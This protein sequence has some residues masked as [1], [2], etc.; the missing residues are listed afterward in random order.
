[1]DDQTN[2]ST[3]GSQSQT[4]S[5]LRSVMSGEK[6]TQNSV[7]RT[8]DT[9]ISGQEIVNGNQDL[10]DSRLG[11]DKSERETSSSLATNR[12]PTTGNQSPNTDQRTPETSSS[13]SSID[14]HQSATNFSSPYLPKV[15]DLHDRVNGLSGKSEPNT[16]PS[17]NSSGIGTVPPSFGIGSDTTSQKSNK[18]KSG[19]KPFWKQRK[20]QALAAVIALLVTIIGGA[21]GLYLSQQGTDLRQ[22]ASCSE[23]WTVT[24]QG[25]GGFD[26]DCGTPGVFGG[27]RTRWCN[28][29]CGTLGRDVASCG[30]TS[31]NQGGGGGGDQGGGGT[32]PPPQVDT[33]VCANHPQSHSFCVDKRVGT[34]CTNNTV[35]DI[36]LAG[37]A[38]NGQPICG[39]VVKTSSGK[40]PNGQACDS[41]AICESGICAVPAEGGAQKCLASRPSTGGDS[42]GEQGGGT[43][44]G[45]TTKTCDFGAF[46]L[47][48]GERRNSGVC[49]RFDGGNDTY[50][51][52]CESTETAQLI[53]DS[54]GIRRHECIASNSCNLNSKAQDG[55]CATEKGNTGCISG[56]AFSD[57]SCPTG[58]RCGL[59]PSNPTFADGTCVSIGNI[60]DPNSVCSSGTSH[61]TN[62]QNCE[63][64]IK[65]GPNP[66]DNP[67][68]VGQTC[69]GPLGTM[70]DNE[71]QLI[72]NCGGYRDERVCNQSQR[73]KFT[74]NNGVLTSSCET[75]NDCSQSGCTVNDNN[76]DLT[77]GG[78][79]QP[80]CDAQ[81]NGEMPCD[82][83][84]I[85][86]NNQCS[87][88]LTPVG[89]CSPDRVN[90]TNRCQSKSAYKD[91]T[92]PSTFRCG[93]DPNSSL[94]DTCQV[95]TDNSTGCLGSRPG[96]A[97]TIGNSS[98]ACSNVGE[99]EGRI[100]C[101]CATAPELGGVGSGNNGTGL[102]CPNPQPGGGYD[103]IGGFIKYT[104]PNGCALT[105]EEGIEAWR[106]YEN[107]EFSTTQP[108]LDGACGQVD[109]LTEAG[110]L[111]TYCGYT[112]YTCDQARC[113]NPD[114]TPPPDKTPEPTP[115]STPPPPGPMCMQ[116]SISP[117][118][119]VIGD[120]V[121][122][123]CGAVAGVSQYTF[124]VILP[125]GTNQVLAQNPA[126]SP[127]SVPFQI[128]GGG[129]HY[130]QC[131]I[132]P[133]GKCYDFEPISFTTNQP[134]N[135]S[136]DFTGDELVHSTNQQF[137]DATS[138]SD[139]SLLNTFN[140]TVNQLLGL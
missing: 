36:G 39:C 130:A 131:Q 32:N 11:D 1:M 109:A 30:S 33:N 129:Q 21:A 95:I 64:G 18:S 97:C 133:N 134:I 111:G 139:Q 31:N 119:P 3:S 48:A 116:V 24:C 106:C 72:G 110:N 7:L 44:G 88:E 74:C 4:K 84:C 34:A 51:A 99:N 15:T 23:V 57:Q 47:N 94:S 5:S 86:M 14:N 62:D 117:T 98:G 122:I 63:S 138:Q 79:G 43:G 91:A 49:G 112:E 2:L 53:C 68:E 26:G 100:S 81:C 107:G 71:E 67:V 127:N 69:E 29:A 6:N 16:V 113:Q 50:E 78:A 45:G 82:S 123:T 38:D 93:F 120:N 35:C 126:G 17:N 65:C 61:T 8:Q 52:N 108:T 115:T 136:G 59:N 114:A 104:C 25:G 140:S 135:A 28:E 80:I 137:Q 46:T 60:N 89:E 13:Q 19:R 9:E 128:T 22:Q 66:N 92:C 27:D 96:E 83:G 124:R 70:Q 58:F 37:R 75:A 20:F 105:T 76:R 103:E 102:M 56:N 40:L 73:A 42:G 54:N 125:N 41:D 10:V 77:C 87:C 101:S 85:S 90:P 55:S 132:C 121:T 12:Q 118:A